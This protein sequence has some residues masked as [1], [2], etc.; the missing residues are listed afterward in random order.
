[1]AAG[2]DALFYS[3]DHG[4]VVCQT[5]VEVVGRRTDIEVHVDSH[6]V[7]SVTANDN[8][9]MERRLQID[10]LALTETNRKGE[11]KKLDWTSGRKMLQM[12]WP[13]RFRPKNC[14]VEGDAE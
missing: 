9:K 1:M 12:Y 7:L 14:N 8:N 10:V 11:L 13:R 4:Y 5:L 2:V 6:T 3:L